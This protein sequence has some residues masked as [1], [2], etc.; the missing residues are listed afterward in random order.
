MESLHTLPFLRE[1]ILYLVLAGI[2]IPLLQRLH[3]NQ[4]L[5]FLAVGLI[6]GPHGISEWLAPLDFL[7]LISFTQ[8]EVITQFGELG[9]IFLMFM[10]GLELSVARLLQLRQ[11]VFAGGS[12]QVII[13]ASMIG[14]IAY[15]F[16]NSYSVSVLLGLVLALSSTAVVVQIMSDKRI[17]ATHHGEAGFSILMFQDLAVV[18]ILILVEM[19]ANHSQAGIAMI[20]FMTLAKALALMVL[21]YLLGRWLIQPIFVYFTKSYRSDVFMALTLLTLLGI[22]WLTSLSGL[23]MALG[24]LMAGLVL[25]ETQFR[26]EVESTIEPFKGLLMGVF[27]MTVGMNIQVQEFVAY[28]YWIPLSVLGLFLIKASVLAVIF[29]VGK[30]AWPKAIETAVLM[31][32]GGEFAF[33]VIGL[34]LSL[35]ILS[36]DLSQF[37]MLVIAI[38]MFATPLMSLIAKKITQWLIRLLETDS[39]AETLLESHLPNQVDG[40]V[41]IAG[42]GRVGQLLG[43]IFQTLEIPHIA[44]DKHTQDLGAHSKT[45]VYLGDIS[46]TKVL[47]RIHLENAAAIV[48]TMNDPQDTLKSVIDIRQTYPHLQIIARARDSAHAEDLLKAGANVAMPETLEV[49]LQLST[50]VL[51]HLGI[52]EGSILHT[53]A[54]YRQRLSPARPM[55]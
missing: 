36:T 50:H 43:H 24:A 22:A 2:L 45:R 25:A 19:M 18:P 40:Q 15:G 21:I 26:H 39:D 35:G 9:V 17:L 11:W 32:Q 48:L 52:A 47:R 20:T 7:K 44:M 28:G 31:G 37:F 1:S 10:I 6:L 29:Y 33:I 42:Y 8:N 30:I 16:G 53:I 49:G 55:P 41:V 23:S 14:C 3:I 46:Q 5:G 12:L 13:T 51:E 4:I 54:D 27:F 34:A 38:S